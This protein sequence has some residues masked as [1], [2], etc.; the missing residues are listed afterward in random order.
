M[1]TKVQQARHTYEGIMLILTNWLRLHEGAGMPRR[2][3]R[4]GEQRQRQEEAGWERSVALRADV[5]MAMQR[6][7]S[8]EDSKLVFMMVC[9]GASGWKVDGRRP[10]FNWA[11]NVASLFGMTPARAKERVDRSIVRMLRYLN[12]DERVKRGPPRP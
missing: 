2:E 4:L 7:L 8:M 11:R 3:D 6:A 10:D 5:E 12:G 9:L 1:Q